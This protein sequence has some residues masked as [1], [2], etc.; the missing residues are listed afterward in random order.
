MLTKAFGRKN[1]DHA[2]NSRSHSRARPRVLPR[3]VR[4]ALRETD[5]R[6]RGHHRR[7]RERLREEHTS[8]CSRRTSVISHSQNGTG[9]VCGLS[10]RNT[11]DPA[12][13][14]PEHHVAQCV[15]QPA[16]VVRLEVDV[17]D[18]LVRF[19]GF[20]AYF[21]VPSGRRWNHSG[22][23]FSHGW[24]GEHWMAKSSAISMPRLAAATGVRRS[25]SRAE[26]RVDASCPPAAPIAQGPRV[27]GRSDEGVVRPLRFVWPIGWIGG[28]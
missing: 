19:G 18:V 2:I 10:T 13:D 28:R 7:P 15:P 4:V 22:C 23:S 25:S 16:P 24:S 6:E 1:G 17:V 26:L 27:T 21:N 14:P 11:L 5:L 8:G 12:V 9:F 20:S 3:E